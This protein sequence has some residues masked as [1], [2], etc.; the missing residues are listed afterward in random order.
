MRTLGGLPNSKLTGN[1]STAIH[2]PV[3]LSLETYSIRGEIYFPLF[4]NTSYGLGFVQAHPKFDAFTSRHTLVEASVRF[5]LFLQIDR[6][7]RQTNA[8]LGR[9][10]LFKVMG[11]LKIEYRPMPAFRAR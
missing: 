11:I 1:V 8:A 6:H 7:L 4:S 10:H 9:D 5:Q 2:P 3:S